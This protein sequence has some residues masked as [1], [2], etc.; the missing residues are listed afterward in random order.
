M[1]TQGSHWLK[2]GVFVPWGSEASEST[3]DDET[4][5]ASLGTDSPDGSPKADGN[6]EACD[7]KEEDRRARKS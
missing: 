4:Y 2:N 5:E 1:S 7:D 3:S 6:R